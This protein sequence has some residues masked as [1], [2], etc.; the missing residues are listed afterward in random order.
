MAAVRLSLRANGVELRLVRDHDIP[1]LGEVIFGLYPNPENEHFT[2]LLTMGARA[3][4]VEATT[5]NAARYFWSNRS[6]MTPAQWALPMA[7]V[8]DGVTVGVQDLHAT[9]FVETRQAASGSYLDPRVQRQ[10]IGTTMRAMMI[11][12]AFVH[13]GATSLMSGYLEGNEGSAKISSRL[14]YEHNGVQRLRFRDR[15]HL[16]QR[17]R[18]TVDRWADFRPRWL[19]DLEVDGVAELRSFLGLEA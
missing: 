19:D 12:F 5:R 6:S 14:G 8:R 10:G 15:S 13:L 1:A 16:E 11:E 2:P 4:D 18:L 3:E 17:L 9:D 7:V